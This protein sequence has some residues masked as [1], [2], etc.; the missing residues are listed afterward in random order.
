M[1][2]FREEGETMKELEELER[3]AMSATRG[4]FT[5]HPY[6]SRMGTLVSFGDISK[7]ETIAT[8]MAQK[9][10]AEGEANGKFYA[11]ASPDVILSLIRGLKTVRMA[12]DMASPDTMCKPAEWI[13]E[14][15]AELYPET[16]QP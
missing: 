10:A 7:G 9:D 4:E 16:E 8:V 15:V 2:N 12:L 13:S 3:L 5:A 14:A 6:N 1:N 11:A